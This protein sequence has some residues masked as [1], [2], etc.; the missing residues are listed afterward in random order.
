MD[1]YED[2]L[3]E[4][5]EHI[6]VIT[7]NRP[8][9]LNALRMQTKAELEDAIDYMGND[10]DILGI[11][12]TGIGRGFIAGSDIN[13]IS[14][15]KPGKETEDMSIAANCMIMKIEKMGK[16]VI[17]AINGYALGGGLELALACDFRIASENA[18]MGVP[19]INLGVAPCY[20]GTQRLPRLIGVSKAKELLFTGRIIDTAEALSIGLVDAT[21]KED[22]L[23]ND[24]V[25]MMNTMISKAPIAISYMKKCIT[26][27]MEMSLDDGLKLESRVAGGLHKK[28]NANE[29]VRAFL[30]KRKPVFRNR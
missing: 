19:E 27:G 1:N 12:I 11:I 3:V 21:S 28:R 4:K 7:V 22:C 23:M 2:I 25:E 10:S 29:G 20:G 14:I 9:C 18:K 24:A 8:K 15:G 6:G 13:E 26:E 16:P 17:A 5:K 30:E